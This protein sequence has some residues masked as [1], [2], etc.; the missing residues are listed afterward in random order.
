MKLFVALLFTVLLVSCGESSDPT[1]AAPTI[2][3]GLEKYGRAVAAST[4]GT[5]LFVSAIQTTKS[6]MN[7]FK[8]QFKTDEDALMSASGAAP[9]NAAYLANI[10]RTKVWS[11]K[12][13]T[14][15]LK[16]MMSQYKIDLVTGD[17]A[18]LSGKTQSMA[19]C[20]SRIKASLG[21][22]VGQFLVN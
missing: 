1:R 8:L 9:G 2:I 21:I 18:N 20:W 13:C 16:S 12:F 11:A 22:V 10:G 14:K 7:A 4:D 5:I 6:P 3:D 17:L 19:I 15:Q